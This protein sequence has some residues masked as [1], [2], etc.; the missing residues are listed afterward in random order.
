[1]EQALEVLTNSSVEILDIVVLA[2]TVV[3]GLAIWRKA[4]LKLPGGIQLGDDT[5]DISVMQ[6]I[7]E[8]QRKGYDHL[9][10]RVVLL[11]NRVADLEQQLI[12]ARRRE[13]DLENELAVERATSGARITE[14]ELALEAAKQRIAALEL[15]LSDARD[16]RPS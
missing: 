11:E 2:A 5:S 9:L 15:E 3:T 14:L 10:D 16:A 13:T 6:T 12:D 1:M 4:K 8:E 7:L